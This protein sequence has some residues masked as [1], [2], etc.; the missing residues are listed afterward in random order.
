MGSN[1]VVPLHQELADIA[2]S[3]PKALG[4]VA[5]TGDSP[6]T[7]GG[8]KNLSP[9]FSIRDNPFRPSRSQTGEPMK[10]IIML[11][12]IASPTAMLVSVTLITEVW[13]QS[14][15]LPDDPCKSYQY[16]CVRPAVNFA[17]LH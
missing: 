7:L 14:H 9:L 11:W 5:R 13:L 1:P 4:L 6:P 17:S 3:A 10:K 16:T 2:R 15:Y 8:H 12:V